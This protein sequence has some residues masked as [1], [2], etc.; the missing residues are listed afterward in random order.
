MEERVT[1]TFP[2]ETELELP[3]LEEH[4]KATHR[5]PF[6]MFFF[7]DKIVLFFFVYSYLT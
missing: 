2:D 1:S 4:S 3:A 7:Q 6:R 5:F